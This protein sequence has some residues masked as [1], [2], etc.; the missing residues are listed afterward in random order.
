MLALGPSVLFSKNIST[1]YGKLSLRYI[2][3]LVDAKS[4]SSISDWSSKTFLIFVDVSSHALNLFNFS[5]YFFSG[6]LVCIL[7]QSAL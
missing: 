7:W 2:S 6:G 1:N 5:L 3:N 4:K